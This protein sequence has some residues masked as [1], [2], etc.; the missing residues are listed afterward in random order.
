MR[1]Q[2]DSRFKNITPHKGTRDVYDHLWA[3]N[4]LMKDKFPTESYLP[5]SI[6]DYVVGVL[7]NLFKI[8]E[9]KLFK[10]KFK[11]LFGHKCGSSQAA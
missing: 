6:E 4:E 1:E 11:R 5:I 7:C 9:C 8:S 3:H 2:Q 10:S